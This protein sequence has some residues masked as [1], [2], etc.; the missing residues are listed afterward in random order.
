MTC[1]EVPTPQSILDDDEIDVFEEIIPDT[2]TYYV[3][4]RTIL[5]AF[6]GLRGIGNCNITYWLQTMKMR[7]A[8]IKIKYNVKFQ[9]IGEWLASIASSIDMS[10]GSTEYTTVTSNE[11]NPDNPQGSTVYL[12]DRNTVTYNGKSYSGLSSETLARFNEM[13]PDIEAEFAAEFRLQFYHG[14]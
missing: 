10:D 4:M 5:W 1:C 13:I 6:Y 7:Y 11:D 2:E 9:A 3:E 8:Q 12:S 14:V